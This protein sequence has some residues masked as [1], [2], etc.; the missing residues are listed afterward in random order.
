[1]GKN[2][3]RALHRRGHTKGEETFAEVLKFSRDKENAK[4]DHNKMPCCTHET[5]KHLKMW[6][7]QVL[8]KMWESILE[9][10]L[11]SWSEG[12]WFNHFEQF[13]NL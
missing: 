6:P 9:A 5:G 3:D 2:R 4:R 1:M 8:V 10:F 7:L 13:G 12:K 11:H